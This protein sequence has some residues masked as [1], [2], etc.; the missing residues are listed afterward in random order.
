MAK[1]IECVLNFSEGQELSVVEEIISVIKG[2]KVLD[3]HS[4]PDH[5]RSVVTFI[6]TIKDV[7][8]GAYDLTE[9][10]LQLLDIR[11]H[12]GVHPFIGVVDVIPFIPLLET[13]MKEAVEAAH[14]L[15]GDLWAKFHL[16]CYLYG[17]AARIKEHCDLPYVRKGLTRPDV[18]EGRHVTGGATAVGARNYLIAF[19]VNLATNDLGIAQSIARNIRERSGGLP[20]VRAI[21]LELA[22]RGITQ[23][24]VNLIDHR[25]TSL[26]KLFYSIHKWAREY[27]VEIVE[28]ELVGLIPA[29][30]AFEGMKEY[31]KIPSLSQNIILDQY[32]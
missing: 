25:E 6:G 31:L 23:V 27:Q 5:N 22:S 18:G 12:Y 13:T 10:A 29:S 19:N 15:A 1:L 32:L 28:S 20:G 8:Q 16:P 26:K 21:G 3:V 30:A 9:R 7:R 4:D 14:Q 24:S 17:E 11:E 2:A